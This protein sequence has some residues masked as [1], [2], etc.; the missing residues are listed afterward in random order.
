[1]TCAESLYQHLAALPAVAALAGSRIY[2]LHAPQAPAGASLQPTVVYRL[3]GRK[4][5]LLMAGPQT[6][7]TTNWELAVIAA[8]Y[9]AGHQLMEVLISNL[10]YFKGQ[11]GGS[12]G[13][14]VEACALQDVADNDDPELGFYAVIAQFEIQYR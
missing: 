1:V 11:L 4:D 8:D 6:L 3:A 10:A 7:A 13:V 5:H 9:D 2:P 14:Y 12:G